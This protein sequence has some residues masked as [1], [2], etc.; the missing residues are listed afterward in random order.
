MFFNILAQTVETAAGWHFQAT[1]TNTPKPVT[2]WQDPLTNAWSPG[3][4]ITWGRGFACLS[5]GDLE[6][7]WIPACR[8][9]LSRNSDFR[10]PDHGYVCHDNH[11]SEYTPGSTEAKNYTYWA[12]VPN[13]PLLRPVNQGD[14]SIPVSVNDSSWIPGPEDKYLPIH[15]KEE[16]I[17]FNSTFGFDAW[18]VCLGADQGCLKLSMQA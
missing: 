10:Q 2:R 7:V 14:I 15:K 13:P 1:S 8:V 12:Y 11:Y 17:P 4:L 3:K 9:K 5:P 18:P 6:P 16:G